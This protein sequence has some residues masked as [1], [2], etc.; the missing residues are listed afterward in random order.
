VFSKECVL[1]ELCSLKNVFSIK[2]EYSSWS[3]QGFFLQREHNFT[4]HTHTHTHK[5]T[6]I[7]IQELH[8]HQAVTHT[9]NH[10]FVSL[11][12]S[13]PFHIDA[14]ATHTHHTVSPPLSCTWHTVS[15]LDFHHVPWHL[16]NHTFFIFS[17]FLF[18]DF[19]HVPWHLPNHTHDLAFLRKNPFYFFIS[20]TSPGTCAASHELAFLEKNSFSCT[21]LS[22]SLSFL[23]TYTNILKMLDSRLA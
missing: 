3:V 5:C 4:T 6:H 2:L 17:F 8:L 9:P 16:T 18:F 10:L 19:H 21:S 20:T 15:R 12:V 14:S 1:C 23:C 11:S 13:S 7:H 22:L